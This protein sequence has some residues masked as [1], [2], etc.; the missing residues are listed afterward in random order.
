[1]RTHISARIPDAVFL[2]SRTNPLVVSLSK[3]SQAKY[4]REQ[5]LFLAEGVKLSREAASLPETRYVLLSSSDGCADDELLEIASARAPGASVVVL[6]EG[7]FGKISTENAP[8]G[9]ITVLNFM[10]RLHRPFTGGEADLARAQRL[11]A[12]DGIQDPGNLGTILRTARTFGYRCVLLCGCA[13]IYHPRAV[14]AAMGALFHTGILMCPD[15]AD[16]LAALRGAGHR[17]LSAAL[18]D[19]SLALGGTQLLPDDC[20]VIG[21]EG[22]GVSAGVLRASD[23]ALRIPMEPGCES[24][25]A[26]G[27]AAVLMWEYYRTFGA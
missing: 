10:Q 2:T 24:L 20:V 5:G 27:A 7:T 4:R 3:L 19:G 8:Q 17:V 21:N 16:A 23:A 15:L 26:A 22:H 6:P 11:L 12:L 13:D 1:M 25:N 14:R 18:C 9:I